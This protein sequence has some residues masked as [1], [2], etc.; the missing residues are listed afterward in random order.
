MSP[1]MNRMNEL[2]AW[3]WARHHTNLSW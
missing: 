2:A 1:V 3:A